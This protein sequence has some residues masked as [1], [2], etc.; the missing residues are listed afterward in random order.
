MRSRMNL[1]VLLVLSISLLLVSQV[2]WAWSSGHTW[3]RRWAL[4][5]LPEWQEAYFGQENPKALA[6]DYV[7]LQD[8]HAGGQRPDLDPYCKVPRGRVS[9]HDVNPPGATLAAMQYYLERI[10]GLLRAGK[11]D[12]AMKFTGVLCHWCED[13]GSLSAHS[14]PVD[15]TTL[16]RLV[17]PPAEFRGK[18]YLFGD[19]WIGLEKNVGLEDTRYTPKLLGSTIS[20][21][22]SRMTHLQRVLQR[23]AEGLLVR[24]ILARIDG[25]QEQFDAA[26]GD[27]LSYNARFVADIVFTIGCL[28]AERMDPRAV[29]E[30]REQRLTKWLPDGAQSSSRPYNRIP[31]L[32]G[33]SMD[34]RRGLHSLQLPGPKGLDEVAF[35]IGMGAPA[36]LSYT[37]ATGG[38]YDQFTARVGIHPKAGL[39]GR[40]VFVVNVNGSEV[41]RTQPITSGQLP[42]HVKVRLPDTPIVRIKLMTIAVA[43]S[44]E[45]HNLAVWA[46][47]TLIQASEDV[48]K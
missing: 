10:C 17:P 5:R 43:D 44:P 37:L 2:A 3:I 16:R 11:H 25:D 27:A 24:A 39:K 38:A 14:S 47:P 20:Q 19:G 1:A 30:L 31:F 41:A 13:P 45:T 6:A 12:E 32:V 28:A 29:E 33:Q 9:L 4:E 22:A 15:E 18:H 46:E 35:G 23:H 7:S 42:A 21:A 34:E 26:V 8:L 40:I 48:D 36:N